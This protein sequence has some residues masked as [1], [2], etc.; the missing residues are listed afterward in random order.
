MPEGFIWAFPSLAVRSGYQQLRVIERN[1]N[2]IPNATRFVRNF[3][4]LAK[5]AGLVSVSNKIIIR[6]R[7]C[8]L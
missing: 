8:F 7:Y 5:K 2:A 3:H 4:F 6:Q 1:R